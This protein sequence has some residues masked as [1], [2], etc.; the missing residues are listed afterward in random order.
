[1]IERAAERRRLDCLHVFHVHGQAIGDFRKP[2]KKACTAAGLAGLIVHDLRRSAVRNMVRAGIPERVCLA[3]SGHKTRAIFDRYQH[4]Q[5]SGPDCG[6]R[7]AADAL[8]AA[9]TGA[10]GA[11]EGRETGRVGVLRRIFADKM[12][13]IS[14]WMARRLAN[15]LKRKRALGDSNTRPLDS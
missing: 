4:R 2:W 11:A 10:R 9:A 7:R 8:A 3:L 14:I 12:R 13:T 1:M 6:G 5:R 15:Y